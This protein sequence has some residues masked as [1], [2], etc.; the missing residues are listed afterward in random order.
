MSDEV[1]AS[2]SV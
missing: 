2:L 1:L